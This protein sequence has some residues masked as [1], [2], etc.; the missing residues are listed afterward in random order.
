MIHPALPILYEIQYKS[1]VR[2]ALRSLKTWRGIIYLLVGSLIVIPWMVMLILWVLSDAKSLEAATPYFDAFLPFGLLFVCLF[3]LLTNVSS[4]A[5]AFTPGE[6][7]FLF[8]GPFAR[9]ELL[10]YKIMAETIQVVIISAVVSIILLPF[11]PLWL[12]GFIGIALTLFFLILLRMTVAFVQMTV[13]ERI[14]VSFRKV[15]LYAFWFFLILGL[16]KGTGWPS[17]QAILIDPLAFPLAI[18]ETWTGA[19]LLTPIDFFVRIVMAKSYFPELLFWASVA[20]GIDLCLFFAVI[21]LDTNYLESSMNAAEKKYAKTQLTKSGYGVMAGTG[22][23]TAAYSLPALSWMGGIGPNLWRQLV[24]AVR[25]S[26]DILILSSAVSGLCGFILFA[27][28]I[29]SE[30]TPFLLIVFAMNSIILTQWMPFDFRSDID[31]MDWLKMIPIG[32]MPTVIGQV[33]IP[34]LIVSLLELLLFGGLLFCVEKN[35]SLLFIGMVLVPSF[36]FLLFGLENLIFLL[37]PIRI[38]ESS[39]GDLYDVGRIMVTYFMKYISLV[40]ILAGIIGIG[41]GGY[42][43]CGENLAVFTAITWTLLTVSGLALLP[44]IAWA[45]EKFDPSIDTPV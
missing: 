24:G 17:V 2:N 43:L 20:A 37:F 23:K 6:T 14:D 13:L 16:W 29:L 9:R 19:I 44:Y 7:E 15:V 35:R 5:I 26:K 36:N 31:R 8:P 22:Q 30:A 18:R 42:L 33:L 12:A 45:F 28:G 32:S 11:T 41:F 4:K 25:N 34:V 27:Q 3:T 1:R 38:V 40:G 39:S 21:R 10:I